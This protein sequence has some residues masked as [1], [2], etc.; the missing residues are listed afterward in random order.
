MGVA[1]HAEATQK[2]VEG[3]VTSPISL[4]LAGVGQALGAAGVGA[5]SP[6]SVP[7]GAWPISIDTTPPTAAMSITLAEYSLGADPKLSD[8]LVGL[9]V[10]VRG[11]R[12]PATARDKAADIYGVLQGLRT[13]PNGQRITQIFWQSEAQIGPDANG[14]HERSIN[15]YVQMNIAFTGSE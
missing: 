1:A 3:A 12:T 7:A 4:L 6:S 10:R 5:W 2:G 15:F 9:N 8:R 13:L 11:D 14:R